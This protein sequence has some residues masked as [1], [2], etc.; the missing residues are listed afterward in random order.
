M[1]VLNVEG[2]IIKWDKGNHDMCGGYMVSDS[3]R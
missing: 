2:S 3:V 1:N